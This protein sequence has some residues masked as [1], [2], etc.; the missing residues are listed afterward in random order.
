MYW[1]FGEKLE[2]KK[3]R[4]RISLFVNYLKKNPG[5]GFIILFMILLMSCAFLLIGKNEKAA[6]SMANW[7]Y[8]FL[9]IGVIIKFIE[10][11]KSK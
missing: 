4:K 10:M 1:V 7:A 2:E 9:V 8:L 11:R 5:S 3:L 6:E